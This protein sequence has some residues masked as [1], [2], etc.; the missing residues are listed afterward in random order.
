M[1]GRS[2]LGTA[3]A[4]AVSLG[5]FNALAAQSDSPRSVA[6]PVSAAAKPGSSAAPAGG[7]I[8]PEVA[9]NPSRRGHSTDVKAPGDIAIWK[10]IT[11]GSYRDVNALR[12]DLDSLHCGLEGSA[13]GIHARAAFVPGTAIPLPCSL[14]ESAAEIIG[15][16]A[17]SLSKAATHAD[18][19]VVSVTELGFTGEGAAIADIY[20]RARQLGLELCSAEVGPQLRLQYLDQPVGEFLRIAM[21]PIATYGGD[22][23]DLTVA[24]GG[25]SLLL[26]GGDAHAD[27][28]VDPSVRFVFVR[29]TRIA[30]PIV[31]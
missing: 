21:E 10:T 29:A 15:R 26:I 1:I 27:A 25:A 31:P 3:C 7:A 23:V 2:I 17:F 20:A 8:A 11:L 5:A 18:L 30:Q 14:G 9:S 22:L 12:E 19:V 16:P 28:I 6:A 24:N 13:A 4:A